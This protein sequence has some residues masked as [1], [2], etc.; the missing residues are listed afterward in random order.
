MTAEGVTSLVYTL[1]LDVAWRPVLNRFKVWED[2]ISTWECMNYPCING[3]AHCV[4]GGAREKLGCRIAAFDIL[5]EQFREILFPPGCCSPEKNCWRY[6]PRVAELRGLLALLHMIGEG[7]LMETW[8]L[9][10]YSGGVWTKDHT[11]C[12]QPVYREL[13]WDM[14]RRY[15]SLDIFPAV[16]TSNTELVMKIHINAPS[17]TFR[18]SCTKYVTCFFSYDPTLRKTIL[19]SG[20]KN[21]RLYSIDCSYDIC[22]PYVESLVSPCENSN[23]ISKKKKKEEEI[24]RRK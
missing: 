2:S 20:V 21:E 3:A 12:L 14:E 23:L 13:R 16:K 17:A 22:G 5:H 19:L 6:T 10:D 11:I 15:S 24:D 8:L 18:T 1:G 9:T 4:Y 7:T